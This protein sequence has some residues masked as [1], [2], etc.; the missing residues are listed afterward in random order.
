MVW[1]QLITETGADTEIVP[2]TLPSDTA[3]V[4]VDSVEY[5][6]SSLTPGSRSKLRGKDVTSPQYFLEEN[7]QLKIVSAPIT[8]STI[9]ANVI[10][11][12]S[13]TATT[14][15]DSELDKWGEIL[16]Y[17]AISLLL[18]D[19]QDE[20]N[21][22]PERAMGYNNLFLEGIESA[23]I[24]ADNDDLPKHDLMSYGGL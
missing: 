18:T 6:G 17:G 3:M 20:S 9:E 1:S 5:N 2:L 14:L 15:P 23:K 10:L 7:G 4:K 24:K 11:Q 22:S 21:F 16:I 12:P 13:F 8:G 19:P